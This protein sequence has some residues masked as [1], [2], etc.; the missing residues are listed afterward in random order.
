MKVTLDLENNICIVEREAQDKP[1]HRSGW[2]GADHDSIFYLRV[3]R[4]LQKQGHDVLSKRMWKDGH[5][6]GSDAT[7]YI[8]TRNKKKGFMVYDGD[9]ALRFAFEDFNQKRVVYLKADTY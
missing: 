5:M 3:R 1:L 6:Y 8:R 4:E 2:Q 7:L 9:Y